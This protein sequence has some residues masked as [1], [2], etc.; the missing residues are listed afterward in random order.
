ML[1]QLIHESVTST[2][3]QHGLELLLNLEADWP[4]GV[5]TSGNAII[6]HLQRF[7]E[8]KVQLCLEMVMHHGCPS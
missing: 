1:K 3:L 7:V 4:E 2:Q 8:A 6:H 5:T